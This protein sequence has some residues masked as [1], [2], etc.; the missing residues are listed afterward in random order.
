MF[1]DN[2]A[3]NLILKNAS[4]R[5]I[6]SDVAYTRNFS[7]DEFFLLY[8]KSGKARLIIN[9]TLY[10]MSDGCFALCTGNVKYKFSKSLHTNAFFLHFGANS[11][12]L[13]CGVY[14]CADTKDAEKLIAEINKEFILKKKNC[15]EI[16]SAMLKNLLVTLSRAIEKESDVDKAINSL[17]LDIQQDFI[18]RKFNVSEYAEKVN[19]SKDRFSV[20]FKNR[21]SLAPYKYQ[22]MLKMDY[23]TDLLLHTDLSIGEISKK[24]GYENPLYFSSAYKKQVGV[25]PTEKRKSK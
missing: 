13:P 4:E 24:L 23:A 7:E 22:L 25:S 3:E 18:N 12:I 17:A 19:L 14:R 6:L 10:K 5:E 20:I 21:F 1:T 11:T 9:N 16:L 8:I 15:E 2:K